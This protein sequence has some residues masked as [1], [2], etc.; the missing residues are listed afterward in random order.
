MFN[1]NLGE[2]FLSSPEPD[3]EKKQHFVL[4][5]NVPQDHD[6]N[7]AMTKMTRC[8]ERRTN[9]CENTYSNSTTE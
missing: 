4:L 1:R 6:N 3:Y 2:A 5:R 7:E 9:G 8:P